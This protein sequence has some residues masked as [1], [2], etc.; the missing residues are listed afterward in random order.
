[1]GLVDFAKTTEFSTTLLH[2]VCKI[3][4]DGF[5]G[6]AMQELCYLIPF[7]GAV[8]FSGLVHAPHVDIHRTYGVRFPGGCLPEL[9]TL[10]A[11]QLP[12]LLQCDG[13]QGVVVV[14]SPLVQ[15]WTLTYEPVR[16]ALLSIHSDAS[17]GKMNGLMLLRVDEGS[18]FA[19]ED[20]AVCNVASTF[21]QAMKHFSVIRHASQ[22]RRVGESIAVCDVK[23]LIREAEAAFDAL[24]EMEF[25]DWGADR[26]HKVPEHWCTIDETG[27]LMEGTLGVRIVRHC[28]FIL[29]YIRQLGVF[30]ILTKSERVIALHLLKGLTNKQI[31]RAINRSPKTVSNHLHHIY[32]KLYA[33]NRQH[34][35]AIMTQAYLPDLS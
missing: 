34:A 3:P 11:L 21:L 15:A 13:R 27:Y 5:Q 33:D 19:G 12:A 25:T 23:G 18:P 28:D 1:M 8:W 10:I 29:L 17:T 9:E 20:R 2:G 35:V 14:V 32:T 16:H 7:D 31:A 22:E 24:V 6:W 30:E 26:H 4:L